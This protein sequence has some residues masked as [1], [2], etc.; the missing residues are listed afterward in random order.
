MLKKVLEYFN[1][2]WYSINRIG[3]EA[4]V[5]AEEGGKMASINMKL[6][7]LAND[8]LVKNDMLKIPV[9]LVRIAENHNID[10]YIQQLPKDVSGAIRYNKE[11]DRFQ[12]LLQKTDPDNRRR[13]TLAH[14]LGHFF[15]DNEVL[16][17]DELHIDY[18]YRTSFS[19]EK[20]IEYFAGALLMDR[21]LLKKLFFLNPSITEL[22]KTFDVSESAMT[23]RLSILGLI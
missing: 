22:A 18:L 12:I 7:A 17:S 6:E 2:V 11:K 14:E 4:E 8:I 19:D 21:G 13:F 3:H 23:V 1:N 20:D 16:K 10:V 9:D 15:L 5:L